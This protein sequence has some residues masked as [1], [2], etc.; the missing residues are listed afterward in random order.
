MRRILFLLLVVSALAG[1]AVP[2]SAQYMY[3]DSNGNGVSDTGDRMNPNGTPTTV[4]VWLITDRNRDGSVV[5]CNTQDGPLTINSYTVNLLAQNGAVTYS[6]FINRQSSF[7]F[8]FGELNEGDGQYKNGFG[9]QPPPLPPGGPYWLMTITITGVAGTPLILINDKNSNSLDYTTFGT[10]CAGNDFD[11]TYKLAGPAGGTDWSDADGLLTAGGDAPPVLASIGNQTVNEGSLLTFTAVAT[12]PSGF[13]FTYAL[14]PGAPAGS[15]IDPVTGVFEWTPSEAQGPA[16]QVITV[17]ATENGGPGLSAAQAVQVSVGEINSAPDLAPIPNSTWNEGSLITLTFSATDADLPANMLFYSLGPGAP[18]GASIPNPLVPTFEW[19]PTEHQGPGVYPV[20]VRVSDGSL[21]DSEATVIT[22]NDANVAPVLAPIGNRDGFAGGPPISFTATATDADLPAQL[23]T[24]SLDAGSPAGA[25]IDPSS[26]VFT[27]SP[28]VAGTYPVTVIVQDDGSPPMSDHEELQITVR[29][30][31][32]PLPVLNPIGDK[33]VNEST[34]LTFVVTASDP[35][36]APLTFSLGPDAPGGATISA[37]GIFQWTPSESHGPGVFPVSVLVSNGLASDS[38]TIQITILEVNNF[39]PS[40]NDGPIRGVKVVNEGSLLALTVTAIDL[41]FP[42]SLTFTLAD[43]L[44]P[45][46]ASITAAGSFTWTPTEAQGPGLYVIRVR[47]VDDGTPVREDQEFLV[48]Q[49]NE[50]NTA[51]VLAPIG[52]KAVAAGTTLLFTATA[53]DTDIPANTLTFS[54]G[55]GAPAGATIDP[56]TGA[57]SWFV[58]APGL[59]GITVIVTDNGNPA[60]SDSE[61]I[62]VAATG[63]NDPPVLGSIGN[64]TADEQ[65]LLTFTATATDPDVSQTLTFSLAPGMPPGST[66]TTGGVFRWTP[67]ESQGGIAWPVTIIVTDNGLGLLSDSETITIMVNEDNLPHIVIATNMNVVEGHSAT[68]QL[69]VLDND[70]PPS[71]KTFSKVSGP[72]FM[73]VSST[74]LVNV[75]PTAGDAGT[76]TAIVEAGDGVQSATRSFTITVTEAE[77]APIADAG[78][79]YSFFVSIP[80]TLDGSGSSDPDGDPL[81]YTWDFGDGNAGSGETTVHTYVAE[82]DYFVTLTVS[83]GALSDTDETSATSA[84]PPPA[85]VFVAGGNKTVR[86]NSGKPQNCVQIEP[87]A[88]MFEI[89]DVDFSSIRMT[90]GGSTIP[91]ISDKATTGSD[92]NG[93]GVDEIT[94]CFS[95]ENLRNLFTGVSTGDYEVVVEGDLVGGGGF[96]GTVTL[97]VVG[98]GGALQAS[99]APN[100]LNPKATLTFTTSRIGALRVDL[101]DVH[102][103]LIRT[104]VD[105]PS[106]AAGYHDV[107]IDGSDGNGVRLASGVY[108]VKIRSSADGDVL[109]ALTILK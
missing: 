73:T 18:A 46:G 19:I 60:L 89:T 32:D 51:P 27:W 103:R 96:L 92:R 16:I 3:L 104:L 6:N 17:R 70:I 62:Q 57:F 85:N 106:S 49:V 8:A 39:A 79:P 86:L 109:K 33:T 87:L 108:Y 68:Q 21:M 76:Y 56:A 54:L 93:N 47:V 95:K 40:I 4:D 77:V 55:P 37:G 5:E 45:P 69:I 14:D 43:A 105:E 78:G 65:I 31:I 64:K 38:E 12:S 58:G 35:N 1:L 98:G 23:L 34:L 9:R 48:V 81:T 99:I 59:F 94:A 15:S 97:H 26:G 82:G 101:F 91:A 102:G 107:T 50:V 83:D 66:I 13:S 74:G 67:A 36:G 71:P 90:F 88:G 29:D 30:I 20:T 75:T 25:T 63:L 10:Q 53:T 41:D 100:P 28:T 84:G 80:L 72:V 11:N 2:A 61:T 7:T 24:F 44:P 22:V 42:S 52:N